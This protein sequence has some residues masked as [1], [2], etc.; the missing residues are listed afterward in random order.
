MRFALL[1][2]F[3]CTTAH[4]QW[5]TE[6][7]QWV[8]QFNARAKQCRG[9]YC[10]EVMGRYATVTGSLWTAVYAGGLTVEYPGGRDLLIPSLGDFVAPD[11]RELPL[12]ARHW[13]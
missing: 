4:S 6:G 13:R 7:V 2:F 8:E 1:F 12:K 9:L 11:G 3:I 5:S 10:R